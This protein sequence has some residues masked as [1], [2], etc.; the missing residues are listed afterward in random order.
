MLT[1]QRYPCPVRS[2]RDHGWPRASA[3]GRCSFAHQM[4]CTRPGWAAEA[5]GLHHAA[6]SAEEQGAHPS[7]RRQASA[8][9]VQQMQHACACWM[10]CRAGPSLWQVQ[11]RR[12]PAVVQAPLAAWEACAVLW[13]GLPAVGHR[14]ASARSKCHQ[15]AASSPCDC[16]QLESPRPAMLL[17][18][19]L[20]LGH[21]PRD[22][23][24]VWAFSP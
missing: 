24:R 12:Q 2:Y 9:G 5:P 3:A 16:W 21:S 14:A 17:C 15:G 23:S 6:H 13:C 8:V 19:S 4:D 20:Q 11:N 18:A 7:H 10:A 22:T 1:A